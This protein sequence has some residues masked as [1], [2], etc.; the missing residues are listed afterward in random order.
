MIDPID[1]NINNITEEEKKILCA[2]II[3]T[4]KIKNDF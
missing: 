4:T 3:S 2:K 1:I